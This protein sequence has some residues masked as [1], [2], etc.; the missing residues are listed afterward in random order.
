M[1]P[2]PHL[3]A[4]DRAAERLAKWLERNKGI[5]LAGFFLLYFAATCLLAARRPLWN[6]ELFTYYIA[7]LGRVAD[8]WSALL[9]GGEQI[10]PFFHL[11]TRASLALGGVSPLFLRLPAVTGFGVM[12]VCLFCFVARRSS[13]LYGFVALL[14]PLVTGAYYYA[15]EARPYGVVLG[16]SGLALVCWQ[17]AADEYRRP[18]SLC[19]L[20]LS[21]AGALSNHYYAV[22]VFL[23]L[24]AG[25]AARTLARRRVDGAVWAAFGM[26]AVVPILLFLPLIQQARA[27]GAAFWSPPQWGQIPALPLMALMLLAA[28]YVLVPSP[29]Q[30]AQRW[31]RLV[32][33]PHGHEIV[34]VFAFAA[35]PFAALLLAKLVTNAFT[36]RYAE[37]AVIGL[38][39]LFAFAVYR[40]ETNRAV[41]GVATVLLL[42][43][44]FVM[45]SARNLAKAGAEAQELRQTGT[46]L[47]THANGTL[48][49]VV[50]DHHTFTQLSHYAPAPVATRLVYLAD[51]AASLRHLG[52]NSML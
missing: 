13:A 5:V 7:R 22:F 30:D 6:D 20:A 12:C 37:P 1:T 8:I 16:F 44:G 24:V 15:S 2:L 3:L 11:T 10:P 17:Q 39:A 38:S 51:P 43:G 46:F 45:A 42:S 32:P 28:V 14:F 19:C 23:A 49:I 52:H 31:G 47:Q 21:L 9:T 35:I 26:A 27:Y 41:L 50:G 25:E 4:L 36:D 29:G 18:L 33:A 34:A 40:L 48:S